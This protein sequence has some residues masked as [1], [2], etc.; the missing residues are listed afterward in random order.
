MSHTYTKLLTHFAFSTMDRIKM[1]DDPIKRELYPYMAAII[2]NEYGHACE[3]GGTADHVHI[4]AD[5]K[6]DITPSNCT[7]DVKSVSSNWINNRFDRMNHFCWQKGFGAFSV[8]RSLKDKTVNYIRNQE[9]H[10]RN[11]SF[12]EEFIALLEKYGVEFDKQFL[13]K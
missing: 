4:L 3:V 2:N 6:P 11:R 12:R 13:W 9:H 5:L 8:S 1:I 7:R 10:H